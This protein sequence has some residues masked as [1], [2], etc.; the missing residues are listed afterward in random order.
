MWMWGGI[1]WAAPVM[2]EVEASCASV[3]VV[4]NGF[5]ALELLPQRSGSTS[6]GEFLQPGENALGLEVEAPD[7]CAPR[8]GLEVKRASGEVVDVLLSVV[9]DGSGSRELVLDDHPGLSWHTSPVVP[10]GPEQVDALDGLVAQ[11]RKAYRRGRGPAFVALN[12]PRLQDATTLWPALGGQ[13]AEILSN[14][15]SVRGRGKLVDERE[16]AYRT[17]AGGRVVELVD[18]DGRPL[19][20]VTGDVRWTVAR[21]VVW[22]DDGPRVVR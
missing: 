22:T 14:T 13:A 18:G 21:Y 3:D 10:L 4:V 11:V 12:G 9:F 6:I 16:P 20:E 8:V 5:S 19:L 2:V 17:L 1:A 7:G 15:V